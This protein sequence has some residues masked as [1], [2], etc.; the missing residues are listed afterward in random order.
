MTGEEE[1]E[2]GRRRRNRRRRIREGGTIKRVKIRERFKGEDT[3]KRGGERGEEGNKE[4]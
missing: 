2:G 4:G 3:V 1:E